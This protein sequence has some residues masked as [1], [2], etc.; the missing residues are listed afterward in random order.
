MRSSHPDMDHLPRFSTSRQPPIE[1]P[2]LSREPYSG[3]SFLGYLKQKGYDE[4]DIPRFDAIFSKDELDAFLQTWLFF[5]ALHEI[6]GQLLVVDDFIKQTANRL[7]VTTERF[8]DYMTLW[9]ENY[10]ALASGE[11]SSTIENCTAY[12]RQVFAFLHTHT[13]YQEAASP[14]PEIWLSINA[15]VD[16]LSYRIKYIYGLTRDGGPPI[17]YSTAADA[18]LRSRMLKQGWCPSEVDRVAEE[19]TLNEFFFISTMDRYDSITDHSACSK[20]VCV[21]SQVDEKTY[22]TKH[23]TDD[24]CCKCS[25][26][27]KQHVC[28]ILEDGGNPVLRLPLNGEVAKDAGQIDVLDSRKTAYIAISH[29][30]ADGRGNVAGNE[31]PVCQIQYL[32]HSVAWMLESLPNKDQLLTASSS[33]ALEVCIW[34]DTL[35]VPVQSEFR[36]VAIGRMAQVY[37]EA[38]AVLVLDSGLVSA[39]FSNLLGEDFTRIKLSRW[40]RRLWTLQEGA[41]AHNLVFRFHDFLMIL[42]GTMQLWEKVLRDLDQSRQQIV[43]SGLD[44]SGNPSSLVSISAHSELKSLSIFK[45]TTGIGRFTAAWNGMLGRR[46]SKNEDEPIILASLLSLDV[47][48]LLGAALAQRHKLLL[49]MLEQIPQSIV[50][51]DGPRM[52]ED[53]WQWAPAS[54]GAVRRRI[55]PSSPAQRSDAGLT[56]SYPGFILL[57]PP[58][59]ERTPYCL[60]DE[61]NQM[62]YFFLFPDGEKAA[63][64]AIWG[65]LQGRSSKYA[66][67][68]QNLPRDYD[69]VESIFVAI[70]EIRNGVV[71]VRHLC[72]TL[73]RPMSDSDR[74]L[75]D[76]SLSPSQAI[77]TKTWCTGEQQQWC[78]G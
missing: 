42:S 34:I 36:R 43:T 50:F 46:A 3:H 62:R 17:I 18:A 14:R 54:L 25:G 74:R 37:E 55:L 61:I 21:A 65:R 52:Q 33:T 56:I 64:D 16:S 12:L 29:V 71:H 77:F 15:L 1:V 47:R 40:M 6:F 39:P 28:S 30:W 76:A 5:G 45:T 22:K 53:G 67:I 31:L 20:G 57:E 59:L 38:A 24:C 11:K 60:F 49:S 27:L 26:P 23:I 32:R 78:V 41:L 35:C 19:C 51:N 58:R 72:R 48:G 2:Y 44:A 13:R 8:E 68:L 70:T 75:I 9:T 7:L 4:E 69:D 63:D 73:F 10:A 66:L